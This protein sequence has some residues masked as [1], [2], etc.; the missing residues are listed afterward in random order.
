[1]IRVGISRANGT[2]GR[3][4]IGVVDAVDDL[5]VGGLYAPGRDGQE[6]LGYRAGG[7]PGE[8]TECDVVIELT[9]PMPPP[10]QPFTL[11]RVRRP[12]ANTPPTLAA[13]RSRPAPWKV[14]WRESRCT[15]SAYS[16]RSPTKK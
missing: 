13:T 9:N 5:A 14:M 1:M 8:L 2:M 3:L 4:T 6:I 15:R 11:L 12:R 16:A 7:E 10:A